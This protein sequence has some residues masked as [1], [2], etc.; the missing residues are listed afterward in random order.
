MGSA[1]GVVFP[2]NLSE[3][4]TKQQIEDLI[5]FNLS[6]NESLQMAGV[7]QDSRRL[8]GDPLNPNATLDLEDSYDKALQES[9]SEP[10]VFSNSDDWPAI[11]REQAITTRN[12]LMQEFAGAHE[13]WAE[14]AKPDDI[15]NDKPVWRKDEIVPLL[16][17]TGMVLAINDF[18]CTNIICVKPR[19][20]L[21]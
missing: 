11:Y 21:Y 16:F 14:W 12:L 8:A 3:T 17:A 18:S 5:D 7:E 4:A 20:V 15:Q 19:E 13:A 9:V 1:D 2:Y 10:E 6:L